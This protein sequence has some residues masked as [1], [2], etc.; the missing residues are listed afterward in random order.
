MSANCI[1]GQ[2]WDS[3]TQAQ[4]TPDDDYSQLHCLPE[5][6]Q[7]IQGVTDNDNA[8]LT[9]S[10]QDLDKPVPECQTILDFAAATADGG[11]RGNSWNSFGSVKLQSIQHQQR[12]NTHYFYRLHAAQPAVS[13][14]WRDFSYMWQSIQNRADVNDDDDDD[15]D[16]SQTITQTAVNYNSTNTSR[17]FIFV[18]FVVYL[19]SQNKTFDWLSV[20][21]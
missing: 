2:F 19:Q 11:G 16:R 9:A 1:V 7:C 17:L 10:F 8:R 3:T 14:Q 4:R 21:I 6:R 12:T 15:A 20:S 13:E 18:F 5:L